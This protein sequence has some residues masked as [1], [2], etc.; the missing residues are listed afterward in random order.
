MKPPAPTRVSS[1]PPSLPKLLTRLLVQASEREL[2]AVV[3]RLSE[4]QV[5]DLLFAMRR[6]G[7][8]W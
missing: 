5:V 6:T 4:E 3:S 1:P 2:N 7:I 8:T